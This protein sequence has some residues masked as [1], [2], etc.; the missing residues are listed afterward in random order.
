MLNPDRRSRQARSPRPRAIARA[1]G[2]KKFRYGGG[3]YTRGCYYAPAWIGR[4]LYSGG[5]FSTTYAKRQ[6]CVNK[7]LRALLRHRAEVN[8][9]RNIRPGLP[10]GPFLLTEMPSPRAYTAEEEAVEQR[11][12]QAHMEVRARFEQ[13]ASRASHRPRQSPAV[14]PARSLIG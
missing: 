2:R 5:V 7:A 14:T 1:E 8:A 9:L 11:L 10:Q 3:V 6:A 12:A 4:T 13:W